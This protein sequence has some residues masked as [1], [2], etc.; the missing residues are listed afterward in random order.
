MKVYTLQRNKF[1]NMIVCGDEIARKTYEI[2]YT[3]SY[4]E[5]MAVKYTGVKVGA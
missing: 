2:I 3:G 5:C 1:N 4:A